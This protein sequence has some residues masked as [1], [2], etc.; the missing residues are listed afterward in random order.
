MDTDTKQAV[1]TKGRSFI[2]YGFA[3]GFGILMATAAILTTKLALLIIPIIAYI[4]AVILNVLSQ[5]SICSKANVSQAFGLAVIQVV[6]VAIMYLASSYLSFMGKPISALFPNS[7]A[8]MQKQLTVGFY[9][10]WAG[11]YAQIISG[12]FLQACPK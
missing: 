5:K 2:L 8:I 9:T 3:I 4:L 10:F 6:I 1:S 7:G 11:L 12:G